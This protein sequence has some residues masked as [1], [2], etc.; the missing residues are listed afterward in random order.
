MKSASKIATKSAGRIRQPGLE[1]ARL[2][3]RSIDAMQIPDVESAERVPSHRQLG[4][5]RRFVGRV[6][7]HLDLEQLPRIVHLADRIDQ[8]IG[9]V[10]LVENR[11]LHR[12]ARQSV[13][14]GSGCGARSLF[15]V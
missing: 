13:S 6:V 14:S 9:D 8:A 10:H 5:G 1:R 2:V 7:Q 11:E 12:H 3:T 15:F 4:Y